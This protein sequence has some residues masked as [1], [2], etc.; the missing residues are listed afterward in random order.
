V[1]QWPEWARWYRSDGARGMEPPPEVKQLI[2]WWEVLR[3][4]ADVEER[5]RMGKNILR[6]QSENLW[7]LGVIGQGPHPVIVS[8]RLRNVP[9]DGYW[10]WDSRWS[11]PY[12]PETWYLQQD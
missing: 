5:I 10:G 3:R 1:T 12:Y 4:T 2:A 8:D 9:T 7:V 11:W 6:S